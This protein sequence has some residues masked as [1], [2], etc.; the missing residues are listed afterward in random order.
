[1]S[2]EYCVCLSLYVPL[3]LFFGFQQQWSSSSA[4]PRC[5]NSLSLLL[6]ILLTQWTHLKQLKTYLFAKAYPICKLF[7]R[8][9]CRGMA[10]LQRHANCHNY[11]YLHLACSRSFHKYLWKHRATI[12]S[13]LYMGP[14]D[15]DALIWS[16]SSAC[17]HACRSDLTSFDVHP[18][19]FFTDAAVEVRRKTDASSTDVPEENSKCI[20]INTVVV[21]S[22]KQFG[23]HVDWSSYDAAGHHR[24]GLAESEICQLPSVFIIQL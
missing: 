3:T 22:G 2:Q 7:V 8:R 16:C 15:T 19:H 13:H 10:T 21:A 20:D 17:V 4:G 11:Y 24:L 9:P 14:N 1:M 5:W 23:G 6:F 18:E 12:E